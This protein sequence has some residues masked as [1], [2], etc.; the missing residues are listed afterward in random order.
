MALY[1]PRGADG[2]QRVPP[3]DRDPSGGGGVGYGNGAALPLT[4]GSSPSGDDARRDARNTTTPAPPRRPPRRPPPPP[5]E[6][7]AAAPI[8]SLPIGQLDTVEEEER[9]LM[10]ALDRLVSQRHLAPL[11][12]RPLFARFA[13]SFRRSFAVSGFLAPRR[14]ERAK[15]GV[16]WAKFGGE[17]AE[18]QRW[19]S[20]VGHRTT[21]PPSSG[22]TPSC[23]RSQVGPSF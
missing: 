6:R 3:S 21:T 1:T 19:L 10:V 22:S 12:S 14:R 16:K 23:S 9:T 17:T 13:P 5:P 4:E 20:G 18:K 2:P 7:R 15:N 11:F 8:E